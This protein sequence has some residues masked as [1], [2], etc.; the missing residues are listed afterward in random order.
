MPKR[1]RRRFA[2]PAA[3]AVVLFSSFPVAAQSAPAPASAPLNSAL[4]APLFYQLLLGEMELREGQPG[5][6]FEV[7][8]DAARRT[9]DEQLFRRAVDIAL[10]SRAGD[11]ALIASRAWLQAQ[12]RSLD[13]LR[14]QLQI[15]SALNRTADAA[16]PLKSLLAMTPDAER[17]SLIAAVP[18]FLQRATDKRQAA[19]LVES[20]LEPYKNSADLR[21]PVLVASGRAWAAADDG[22]LALS[23]A[24]EA[25]AIDAAAPGPVLLA[26]DLM[27]K[28]PEAEQ[29]VL[30]QLGRP[31]VEPAMRLAYARNLMAAQR[32]VD[33][34]A[35]VERVT[36]ESPDLAQ[37]FLSL[38]ALQL[39]LRH[40]VAA[41]TA[42]QRYLQLAGTGSAPV[43]AA[44][45]EGGDTDDSDADTSSRQGVIQAWL[46]LAQAAEQRGDF[47]A[48]ETWLG[49]IDDPKRAL[50]VQTRRATLMARQGKL[51]EA[52]ETV[53]RAP[54]REPGDARAKLLAEAGVLRDVKQWGEAFEVLGSAAMRF[55]D[56]SDLLYEQAMVAEKM[57]RLDEMERLLRRVIELKPDSAQAHN[58]LGYSLADRSQRLP[59]ARVLI[60]RALE[61]S[62]G[63]PFITDSLGWVEYRLGELAEATRLLRQAYAARPDVEIGAHLGEVLWAA[64]QVEEARRIWA[65][66]KGRDAA[67]DV[68]RETLARLKVEL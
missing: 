14:M 49:K 66:S 53:R 64:G 37:P 55:P 3:M 61:L 52:R 26:L 46:M 39:E 63:D 35:Q 41:E 4:D 24:R 42:L 51:A 12:P 33:A 23:L 50:E 65:E 44:T 32:L 68:L 59:E 56:D 8:L 7:I 29:L 20:L 27:A 40:P 5:N 6:A 47:K 9:R 38:G 60:R 45:A 48:A 43:P 58:A 2:G 18:R 1:C 10:Q 34:V 16:E 36:T 15:L 57:D 17:A 31:N 54:E 62:P 28:Q 22:A 21:V 30:S 11:Q 19:K 25:H 67:N 13:A